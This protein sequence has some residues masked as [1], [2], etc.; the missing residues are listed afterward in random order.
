MTFVKLINLWLCW[1]MWTPPTTLFPRAELM[2]EN[3]SF[4]IIKICGYMWLLVSVVSLLLL[5]IAQEE[6]GFKMVIKYSELF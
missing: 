3:M 1:E 5:I 6:S 2:S 4:F